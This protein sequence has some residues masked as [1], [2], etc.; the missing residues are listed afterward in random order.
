MSEAKGNRT[1]DELFSTLGV[2]TAMG[3]L[4]VSIGKWCSPYYFYYIVFYLVIFTIILFIGR[5]YNWKMKDDCSANISTN[6]A[7]EDSVVKMLKNC[8]GTSIDDKRQSSNDISG[9]RSSC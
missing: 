3:T 6:I 8:R 7:R 4:M 5:Y 9:T 1:Y 2:A